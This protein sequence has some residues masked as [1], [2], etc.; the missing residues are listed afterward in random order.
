MNDD[1]IDALGNG[2]LEGDKIG[3]KHNPKALR[4]ALQNGSKQDSLKE[5]NTIFGQSQSNSGGGIF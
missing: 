4:E 3:Q 5:W 1:A 2:K